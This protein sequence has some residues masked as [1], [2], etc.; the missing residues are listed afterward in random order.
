M[1]LGLLVGHFADLVRRRRDLKEEL[2][3]PPTQ[4]FSPDLNRLRE[5][6]GHHLVLL[7]LVARCDGEFAVVEREAILDHCAKLVPLNADE[8]ALIDAYLRESRPTLMQLAPALRQLE[9][10]APANIAALLDAVERVI[11]ADGRL[12][13]AELRLLDHMRHELAK[14]GGTIPTVQ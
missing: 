9:A 11:G 13:P 5:R 14:A 4:A 8:R 2:A 3:A 10:E 7:S 6:L 12:D 1:A